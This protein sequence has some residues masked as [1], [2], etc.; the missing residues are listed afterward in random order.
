MIYNYDDQEWDA[1]VL[2]SEAPTLKNEWMSEFYK[3]SQCHERKD[4]LHNQLV[5]LAR[6]SERL[7]MNKATEFLKDYIL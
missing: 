4:S 6:V 5:D 1:L 3:I 7:G 2:L